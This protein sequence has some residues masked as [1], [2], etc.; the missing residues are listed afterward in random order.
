MR[1]WCVIIL[2]TFIV[3]AIATFA[4]WWNYANLQASYPQYKTQIRNRWWHTF[5]DPFDAQV[6]SIA[7]LHPKDCS[8]RAVAKISVLECI[9][10]ARHQ[11]QAF[12]ARFNS[13]GIDSC[14]ADGIVGDGR[15]VAYELHFDNFNGNVLL[16]ERSCPTPL[17]VSLTETTFGYSIKCEPQSADD[18]DFKVIRD[19]FDEVRK[20]AS[21]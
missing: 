1:R 2:G 16:A 19:D 4:F 8:P 10:D 18:H 21:E 9:A 12:K 7:G 6:R 13:C 20:R 15:G 11:Q 14:G 5:G 17:H 3:G